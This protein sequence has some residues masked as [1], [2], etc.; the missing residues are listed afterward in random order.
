MPKKIICPKCGLYQDNDKD[1]RKR[2]AKVKNFGKEFLQ[3]FLMSSY[4]FC[5]QLPFL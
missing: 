2:I 5:Y 1:K 3:Y 4:V